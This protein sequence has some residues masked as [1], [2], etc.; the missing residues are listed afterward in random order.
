MLANVQRDPQKPAY[1]DSGGSAIF[2][3]IKVPAIFLLRSKLTGCSRGAAQ[4]SYAIGSPDDTGW[5]LRGGTGARLG[6]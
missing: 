5:S 3:Y 6:S 4:I 2:I 1:R